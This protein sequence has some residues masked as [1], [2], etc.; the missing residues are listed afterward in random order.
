M[1]VRG[2]LER[3]AEAK[4]PAKL[5]CF[6]PGPQ[7]RQFRQGLLRY[8]GLREQNNYLN[9]RLWMAT[10]CDN[11]AQPFASSSRLPAIP[12]YPT[13]CRQPQGFFLLIPTNQQ[14]PNPREQHLSSCHRCP[15]FGN[16]KIRK[17][18]RLIER[19]DL[20]HLQT[21]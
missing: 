13:R 2:R 15:G 4:D 5:E 8:G 17:P 6:F 14:Q 9:A 19:G 3:A 7:H 11:S 18:P 1:K 16:H 20:I 10:L 12:T 21:H